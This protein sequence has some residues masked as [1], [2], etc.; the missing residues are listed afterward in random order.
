MC[1]AHTLEPKNPTWGHPARR[2][3]STSI[4]R[5]TFHNS[6]YSKHLLRTYYMLT[7]V[8]SELQR[9]L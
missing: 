3:K 2:N 4:L 7:A 5:P 1:N 6:I 8:L 9:M